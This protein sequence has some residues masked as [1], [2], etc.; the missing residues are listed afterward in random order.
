[1]E[2][3]KEL[4]A[5]AKILHD[6]IQ[7]WKGQMAFWVNKAEE[8]E[9]NDHDPYYEEAMEEVSHAMNY[10]ILKGEWENK[11]LEKL[12]N[13]IAQSE[14]LKAFEPKPTPNTEPKTNKKNTPRKR[15]KN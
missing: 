9:N 7:W 4:R 8:W 13:K 14:I 3:D 6:S 11:E 2:A 1:M 5:R 15:K 10:L 12:E